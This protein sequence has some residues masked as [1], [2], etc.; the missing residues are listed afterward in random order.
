MGKLGGALLVAV[1]A[2]LSY[3]IFIMYNETQ[4]PVYRPEGDSESGK[5]EP[6]ISRNRFSPDVLLSYEFFLSPYQGLPPLR[7]LLEAKSD[8]RFFHLGSVNSRPY[9]W[10]REAQL[11]EEE[12]RNWS[13]FERMREALNFSGKEKSDLEVI[14]PEHLRNNTTLYVHVRT[15]DA[16][17]GEELPLQAVQRLSSP[18]VPDHLKVLKR[19][20]LEDPWGTRLAEATTHLQVPPPPVE[21]VPEYIQIG[22]VL[23][24]RPLLTASLLRTFGPN[25]PIVDIEK[26]T[27]ALPIH[28]N[29]MISPE[30][31]H[32]PLVTLPHESFV[33]LPEERRRSAAATPLKIKYKPTGYASWLFLLI[34]GQAVGSLQRMQFSSYDVNSVKMMMGSSSPWVLLLVYLISLLHLVFEVLA[35]YSDVTFWRGQ[36]NLAQNF[37]ASGLLIEMALEIVTILY[38]RDNGDSFL[39]QIFIFLRLLLNAWKLRKLVTFTLSSSPPYFFKMRSVSSP[40]A[41][42]A[43]VSETGNSRETNKKETPKPVAVDFEELQRFENSCMWYLFLL[44]LPVV[45]GV[46]LHQLVYVPQK[47]WWS[48]VVTSLATCGYT[49]GF[50]SMTPQLFRN[51]KL[52]SVTHLPWTVLGY[53]FTNTFID[54]LFSCF[55]RMPKMHRM[56]VFRDD[57]VFVVFLIQRWLYRHN[58]QREDAEASCQEELEVKKTK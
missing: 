13:F 3:S 15:R 36:E 9:D 44:F 28:V 17:S 38:V 55:I 12:Q 30:D 11:R 41:S 19:Y 24:H 34:M 27:Y 14:V 7:N 21:S 6:S 16:R 2:Y 47:G 46:S 35:L 56:S 22:P 18:V 58:K 49:F 48:W 33:L 31:E 51:Y 57:V 50:V 1:A 53:Q 42:E 26:K 5:T 39:V 8:K 45:I 10:E 40:S 29:A 37:S 52:Q 54:D 43:S 25:S 4:P 23:E 20:L 32:L